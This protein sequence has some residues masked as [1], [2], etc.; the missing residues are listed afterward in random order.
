M[1]FRFEGFDLTQQNTLTQDYALMLQMAGRAF[2]QGSPLATWFGAADRTVLLRRLRA[3]DTVI[4]SNQRTITFVNR[5]GG[6]LKVKYHSLYQ[7]ELM[8]KDSPGE[9]LGDAFAYAFPVDRRSEFGT[10]NTGGVLSHVGSGMRIY[11]TDRYFA[12]SAAD[13]ASTIYHEITHKVLATE[14]YS[15]EEADC[16][17]FAAT[18]ARA[19]RNAENYGFFLRAC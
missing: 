15:Y 3:M 13:R 16:L 11:I 5:I 17:S 1:N 14:D 6:V 9:G 8:P 19:M 10:G 12:A 7:P 2:D 4:K 18:P